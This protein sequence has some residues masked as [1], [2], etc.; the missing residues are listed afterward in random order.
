MESVQ[1]I[2]TTRYKLEI[3][4][5]GHLTGPQTTRRMYIRTTRAFISCPQSPVK[6]RILPQPKYWTGIL[7]TSHHRAYVPALGRLLVSWRA[8]LPQA[9]SLIPLEAHD[10]PPRENIILRMERWKSWQSCRAAIGYGLLSGEF[11]LYVRK[12][13]FRKG[14]EFMNVS[15]RMMPESNVYGAWPASGEI[16][17]MESKGNDGVT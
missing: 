3:M 16:D 5:L 14:H 2:G 7:S 11:T 9:P 12:R 4:V 15:P 13:R 6:S 17:I 10:W 8:I 1:T